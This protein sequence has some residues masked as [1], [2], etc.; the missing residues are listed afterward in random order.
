L[1]STRIWLLVAVLHS[2]SSLGFL[3]SICS[4]CL[5]LQWNNSFQSFFTMSPFV[6]NMLQ[7]DVE[8]ISFVVNNTRYPRYYLLVDGIYPPRSC[9]VTT[10]HE[11]QDKMRQHF[12]ERQE[13]CRKDVE[14]AFSTL[15]ARLP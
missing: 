5:C 15:Q 10:I 14:H 13:A 9:F 2:S 12:K 8:D 1:H 7:G 3:D 4:L 11:P 6:L